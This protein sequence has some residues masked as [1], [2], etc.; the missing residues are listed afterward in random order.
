MIHI[1]LGLS[2]F[3]LAFQGAA[4]TP[5]TPGAVN[6]KRIYALADKDIYRAVANLEAGGTQEMSADVVIKV[7]KLVDDKKANATLTVLNFKSTMDEGEAPEAFDQVLDEHGMG[8]SFADHGNQIVY[9]LCELLAIVPGS[10]LKPGD[11]YS[12]NLHQTNGSV[13][14]KGRFTDVKDLEGK[15]VAFLE[16]TCTITPPDGGEV[17]FKAKSQVDPLT[18]KVLKCE[19]ELDPGRISGKISI[20]LKKPA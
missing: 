8:D 10:S 6:L 16:W 4:Q 2:I 3:A 12:F 17:S 15:K 14:G 18:G 20:E 9:T 7:T 1:A 11:D 5:T 13:V 19:A